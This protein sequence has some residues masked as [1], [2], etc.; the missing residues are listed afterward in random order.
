MRK[1][2]SKKGGKVVGREWVDKRKLLGRKYRWSF[3][4]WT[5]W[6]FRKKTKQRKA[7]LLWRTAKISERKG[8][9]E[10]QVD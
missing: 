8:R 1:D 6:L 3:T 2:R 10:I 5:P 4:Y 7:R 9:K